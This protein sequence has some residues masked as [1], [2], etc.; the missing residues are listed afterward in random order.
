M[1]EQAEM[2]RA[3][4]FSPLGAVAG[5][6][7]DFDDE[8]TVGRERGHAV[9]I[10]DGLI[11]KDHARIAFDPTSGGFLLEDLGSTNGTALDGV[12]VV[13]RERLDHLHVITFA[14][15]HEFVFQDLARTRA[16]HGSTPAAKVTRGE[17]GAPVTEPIEFA[18]SPEPLAVPQALIDQLGA[19]GDREDG[20]RDRS[21]SVE[22]TQFHE[23]PLAIPSGIGKVSASSVPESPP[24]K[25]S[26]KESSPMPGARTDLVLEVDLETG[27]QRFP[28]VYGSNQIG[29]TA[30]A[31]VRL[32]SDHVSRR[33]AMLKVGPKITLRDQGSNNHT[34]LAGAKIAGEVQIEPGDSL[35]FGPLEA[36]LVRIDSEGDE[37][38]IGGS[39][40][41]R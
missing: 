32:T 10:D 19:P 14:G 11:S 40:E 22:R 8:A 35:A 30:S 13:G 41:P 7:I 25:E 31:A 12:P 34:Y 15:C 4:L 18:Q 20:A 2:A 5:M 26:S 24:K 37:A 17:D 27:A 21:G 9:V 38:A 16:R 1:P 29:R 39:D 33:H 6:T 28:L 36:R 23:L 3:R